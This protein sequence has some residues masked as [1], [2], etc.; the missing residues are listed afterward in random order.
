MIIRNNSQASPAITADHPVSVNR[1]EG[2]RY[3]SYTT[4]SGLSLR[5]TALGF[6]MKNTTVVLSVH[7]GLS[8]PD[9]PLEVLMCGC[10]PGR[11][12]KSS[13]RVS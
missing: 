11:S 1:T 13:N 2:T 9:R 3:S 4:S 5:V 7:T 6:E 12:D 8:V 10:F